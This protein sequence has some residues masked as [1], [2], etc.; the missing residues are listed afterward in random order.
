VVFLPPESNTGIVYYQVP[1]SANWWDSTPAAKLIDVSRSDANGIDFVE[2]DVLTIS[3]KVV[4]AATRSPLLDARVTVYDSFG[5]LRGETTPG[6]DGQYKIGG[7]LAGSYYVRAYL[8]GYY[9]IWYGDSSDKPDFSK[10]KPVNLTSQS[11]T[12][13]DFKLR[14]AAG[15]GS[16]L[17]GLELMGIPPS[18][19][20]TT[21][22]ATSTTLPATTTT[23]PTTTTT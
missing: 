16:A 2:S 10:A 13:I 14:P 9:P 23:Q 8:A 7:L 17:T 22:R 12:A 6:F 19:T 18:T 1:G 5:T 4:D 15:V 21:P 3:G 11:A 20:T